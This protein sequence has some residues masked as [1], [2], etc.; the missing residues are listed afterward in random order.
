MKK[1]D[2]GLTL[3]WII[4]IFVMAVMLLDLGLFFWTGIKMV[5][6]S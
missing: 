2:D 3:I 1:S 5:M 6:N 4:F